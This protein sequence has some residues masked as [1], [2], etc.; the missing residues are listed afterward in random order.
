MCGDNGDHDFSLINS[1]R[2][3]AELSPNEFFVERP[4]IFRV[5]RRVDANV[6][7]ATVDVLLERR[8]LFGS[9]NVTGCAEEDNDVEVLE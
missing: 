2:M 5:C 3:C 8:L 6:A 1:G 7:A 9:E 4:L